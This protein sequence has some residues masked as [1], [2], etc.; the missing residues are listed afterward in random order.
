M[1]MAKVTTPIAATRAS[2]KMVGSRQWPHET[3]GSSVRTLGEAD[4]NGIVVV[5]VQVGRGMRVRVRGRHQTIMLPCVVANIGHEDVSFGVPNDAG[6]PLVEVSDLAV[7]YGNEVDA[8]RGVNFTLDYGESLAIVGESGSG[9]STLAKCLVGLVQPPESRGTVKV[10]GVEMLGASDAELRAV[11]WSTVALALQGSPFNPVATVGDQVAEPLRDRRGLSSREARARSAELAGEVLLD[12]ALLDRY[13]HELSGGQRRRATLAMVLALDP[14]L[15][16]LDEPTAG[17]DPASRLDLVG[18]IAGLAESRGFALIVISHDLPDASRLARRTMVMYAGEVFEEGDTSRVI[19]D[20]AHPYTWALVNAYPVMTTTKDLRPIRG[21][22]PDPRAVPPGCPYHPRCTQAEAICSERRPELAPSRDRRVLCHFGGL[23]TLLSAHE[24]AK[25]FG[26]GSRR[27]DALRGVS[28]ALR[29]GE[30]LGIVGPSG[31]GKSTLARILSGHLPWD[32]GQ[33]FLGDEALPTSWRGEDRLRRRRI[34]LVMQD[35][36][37]ALSPRLT[38]DELV[39]EPLAIIKVER[40]ARRRA[41]AA[42][43]QSVG[44]PGEGA[45]LRT[46]TH[47]LSGGQLQRVALARALVSEPK[48]LV[49]DEP[50]AMLDASEQARLMVVLRERQVEMGLGLIFISHDLALV[51]KVTDRIVVLDDGVIVEEGPSAVVS[52]SP[53]SRTG[54]LLVDASPAFAPAGD[55]TVAPA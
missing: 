9:K 13:P 22:P 38:V 37:D 47:E 25:S 16:V 10:G 43:L 21:L 19:G 50:T 2:S 48:V 18:R 23:K 33:V 7:R 41:V 45:F 36:A 55:H 44:L 42:A 3:P 20:P 27:V 17:L 29:E 28:I 31:S 8:V 52:G 46:R 14:P 12:P 1:A 15:V 35:P 40:G 39:E 54:R 49:A 32:S 11:R 24:I 51:R 4:D 26:R 6:H 34:Q 5:R 53:Q 30:S